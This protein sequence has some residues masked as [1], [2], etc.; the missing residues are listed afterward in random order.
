[1]AEITTQLNLTPLFYDF[2]NGFQDFAPRFAATGD[3]T[4]NFNFPGDTYYDSLLD[5]YI[6]NPTALSIVQKYFSG[7]YAGYSSYTV[8][9]IKVAY[10]YPV[11]KEVLLDGS[12]LLPINLNI[13]SSLPYL[14]PSETV[15]SR[16]IYTFQGID[17]KVIQEVIALNLGTLDMYRVE[18]TFRYYLI[19]KYNVTYETQSNRVTF[20][21]PSLNTSLVNLIN[22]QTSKALAA[23]LNARGLSVADYN[24]LVTSVS[25]NTAVFTNMYNVLQNKFAV[26]FGIN[27]NTY[28]PEFF[29]DLSS[30]LFIQNAIGATGIATGYSL[31]VLQKGNVPITSSTSNLKDSQVYW[32][33]LKNL[34]GG[35]IEYPYNLTDNSSIPYSVETKT[36][37]NQKFIDN[38]GF[39]YTDVVQK[40][41]DI[42]IPIQPSKY[43]I[44][45]FRSSVRQNLQ[46]ETLPL[47][48]Y[49]RYPE[50]NATLGG[51]VAGYFDMSYS[52]VYKTYNANM[53]NI[54]QNL[55][56]TVPVVYAQ[57]SNAALS[58]ASAYAL[59]IQN[60]IYYYQAKTPA[61]FT[62]ASGYTYDM[63]ISAFASPQS[64]FLVPM[65]MFLYH[66]RGAFMA[67]VS[68]VRNENAYHYKQKTTAEATD[69]SLTISFRAYSKQTYYIILRSNLLSFQNTSFKIITWFPTDPGL[70]DISYNLVGFDP[71]TYPNLSNL[72]NSL[73]TREYDRNFIQLPT[74][75]NLM[76][77]DPS[78]DV[79][80]SN[81]PIPEPAIGYDISGVSTDLTDYKGYIQATPT[82]N[83]PFATF[84]KDPLTNFSFQKLSAYD[85]NSQTYFYSGSSN[86]ILSPYINTVYPR[87]TVAKRQYK[88]VHWYDYNYIPQQYNETTPAQSN[89]AQ[90]TRY[91]S[92]IVN[93]PGYTY[94]VSKAKNGA[95]LTQWLVREKGSPSPVPACGA[96]RAL[97]QQEP[98]RYRVSQQTISKYKGKAKAKT[99][100]SRNKRR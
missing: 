59:Q 24:N 65:S 22:L 94:D 10:Y 7:Q 44:F 6:P 52:Y 85:S 3:Y 15:R 20:S 21:S 34:V 69:S 90:M 8:D 23:E 91:T 29:A 100:G 51:N 54:S 99:G 92:N 77:L 11:L 67:D 63:N 9:E 58:N 60:S 32:P 81:I 68:G 75:S 96:T 79:F 87:K 95:P 41:G 82:S 88:I 93:L 42:V 33:Q 83:V 73:Y 50:Y 49:Y 31:A 14:L 45:R 72:T 35:S 19:N 27:F 64:T 5:Q 76:G 57:T 4:I 55:I 17:D 36:F 62:D 39:V 40:A 28:A 12:F 98:G 47:P 56:N 37:L 53:D 2:P 1:L 61:P 66:D 26:Y 84:R 16:C 43:T 86:V 70:Q 48:Y 80:N 38:S 89:L 25:L 13:V 46:V 74:A 18:H 30:S 78:S 97:P 71:Y